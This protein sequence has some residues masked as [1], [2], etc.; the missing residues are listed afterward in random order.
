MSDSEKQGDDREIYHHQ[1]ENLPKHSHHD[2]DVIGEQ[3]LHRYW[4]ANLALL[5]KLL[6]IW[7]VVSYGCAILLR[8]WLNEFHFF[9]FKLGFWFAQQGAIYVFVILIFVYAWRMKQIDREYGVDDDDN[10]NNNGRM[11]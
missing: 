8:E 7:F 5:A 6:T 4:R 11:D 10:N 9:G 1:G 3:R 2:N